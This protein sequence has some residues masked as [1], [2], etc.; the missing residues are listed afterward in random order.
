M[1]EEEREFLIEITGNGDE[2]KHK[3]TLVTNLMKTKGFGF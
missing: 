3:N 1:E 2:S